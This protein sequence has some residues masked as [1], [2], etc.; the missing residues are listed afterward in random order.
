MEITLKLSEVLNLNQILKNIIDDKNLKMDSLFKFQ[1]LGIMKTFEPYVTNFDIIRNEK[2]VEYG[3]KT[4]DG[5][6][7]IDQNDKEAMEKFMNDISKV[8]NGEVTINM[9]KLKAKDVFDKGLTAE[10]LVGLYPIIEQ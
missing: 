1:L 7:S 3:K 9:A 6:A 2:V 8:V 10:Y 4:D 5:K